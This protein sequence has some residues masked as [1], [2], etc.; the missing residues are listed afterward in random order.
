MG[1][2]MKPSRRPKPWQTS[3][4]RSLTVPSRTMR[5]VVMMIV[6]K[7]VTKARSKRHNPRGEARSNGLTG[8]TPTGPTT[9]KPEIVATR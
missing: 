3:G 8:V 2:L 9:R 6:G 4:R 7:I 1:L 5:K